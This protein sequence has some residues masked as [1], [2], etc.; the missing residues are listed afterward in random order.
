MAALLSPARERA[1]KVEVTSWPHHSAESHLKFTEVF[2]NSSTRTPAGT[3]QKCQ[4][5]SSTFLITVNL[6]AG[7]HTA[8]CKS[9]FLLVAYLPGR[10][11]KAGLRRGTCSTGAQ[12]PHSHC[13]FSV[14]ECTL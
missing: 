13:H 9:F 11:E 8:P 3:L 2:R 5:N 12:K 6:L 7:A 10:T 1:E 14:V 4:R